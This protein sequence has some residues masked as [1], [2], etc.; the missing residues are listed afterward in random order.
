RS[1]GQEHRC[2]LAKQVGDHLLQQVY[3][4]VLEILLVAHIRLAHE[5][6]HLRRRPGDR[7]ANEVDFDLDV[8]CDHGTKLKL[9]V[10]ENHGESQTRSRWLSFGGDGAGTYQLAAPRRV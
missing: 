5:S 10:R 7:V 1:G 9:A 2:F 3:G 6:T 8:R 4:R